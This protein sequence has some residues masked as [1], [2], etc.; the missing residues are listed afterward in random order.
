MWIVDVV[1]EPE[2]IAVLETAELTSDDTGEGRPDHRAVL[3]L[4]RDARRKD[5]D[6]VHMTATRC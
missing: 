2:A 1:L 6:V 5:V 4:L 3:V